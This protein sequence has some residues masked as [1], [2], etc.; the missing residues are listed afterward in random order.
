MGLS[1]HSIVGLLDVVV[2][3]DSGVEPIEN[4]DSEEENAYSTIKFF[5]NYGVNAYG[6]S[7]NN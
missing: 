1:L 5:A 7:Q 4:P 2:F 3:E 6:D